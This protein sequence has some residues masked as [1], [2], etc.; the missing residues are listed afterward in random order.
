MRADG[1]KKRRITQLTERTLKAFEDDG[2]HEVLT[3]LQRD[4]VTQALMRALVVQYDS[5]SMAW[6]LIALSEPVGCVACE[7]SPLDENRNLDLTWVEFGRTPL[8]PALEK[9]DAFLH[10][11][12]PSQEDHVNALVVATAIKNASAIDRILTTYPAA[13]NGDSH[14]GLPINIA[15]RQGSTTEF[16]LMLKAGAS[17][18]ADMT[19]T[20]LDE[21]VY[22]NKPV[23]VNMLYDEAY[24]GKCCIPM[25]VYMTK[26]HHA[27]C[28]ASRS[29]RNESKDQ[30]ARFD[31][32]HSLINHWESQV[33]YNFNL[34]P[35]S[36]DGREAIWR[37]RFHRLEGPSPEWEM[38]EERAMQKEAT[39]MENE[40]EKIEIDPERRLAKMLE[41][42]LENVGLFLLKDS[43]SMDASPVCEQIIDTI[44]IDTG[45]SGLFEALKLALEHGKGTKV[46]ELITARL[47]IPD[48][49]LWIEAYEL[50]VHNKQVDKAELLMSK[51]VKMEFAEKLGGQEMAAR[52]ERIERFL[53][54]MCSKFHEDDEDESEDE[55]GVMVEDKEGDEE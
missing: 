40:D 37:G 7:R 16:R 35:A 27:L 50:A 5:S 20:P 53:E 31:G 54:W 11:A 15:A 23:I 1:Q 25:N 9:I 28:S 2:G 14:F 46:I 48:C 51:G 26:L 6:D 49:E 29:V 38:L 33:C 18:R 41:E 21:A 36:S 55:G 17:D 24:P 44:L 32:A 10:S 47:G 13:I 45:E 39:M 30:S 3:K 43:I 34:I 4:H 52:L 42:H 12:Y 8:K 22:W 19:T